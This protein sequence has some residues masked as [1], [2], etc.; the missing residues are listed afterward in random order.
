MTTS[1]NDDDQFTPE[2]L[3]FLQADAEEAERGYSIEYLRT[4]QRLPGRPRTI[5]HQPAV[6][7][8]IRMAPDQLQ[9]VDE[10][11]AGLGVNRSEIIRRAISKELATV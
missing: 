4:R 8:R 7:V 2:Q 3:A 9:Q 10:L 5:S 11:A 6:M 1:L